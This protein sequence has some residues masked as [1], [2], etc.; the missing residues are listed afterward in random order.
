LPGLSPAG[1]RTEDVSRSFQLKFTGL[2]EGEECV[3][4]SLLAQSFVYDDMNVLIGRVKQSP[5]SY[6]VA[7]DRGRIVAGLGILKMGQW[8]GGRSVPAAGIFLVGVAPEVRGRGAATFLL[9][10]TLKE[11]AA[12]GFPISVLFPSTLPL[13]QRSGYDRAGVRITYEYP[14]SEIPPVATGI[15][16]AA[17]DEANPAEFAPLYQQMAKAATGCLDRAPFTW[18]RAIDPDR[19]K[20]FRYF[21]MENNQRA[22]YVAFGQEQDGTFEIFDYCANSR[23]AAQ[24]ILTF[25]ARQRQLVRS[26]TWHGG[27][28]D[29]LLHVLPEQKA[30]VKRSFEWLVRVVD[31]K[32]ALEYRGWPG[33]VQGEI[34]FSVQDDVM[35]ANND[36]FVLSVREGRGEVKRGGRGSVSIDVRGLASLYTGH[37][38][39]CQLQLLGLLEGPPDELELCSLLFSGPR[40]WM[41]DIF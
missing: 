20:A 39:P 35:P 3:L 14:L 40:P 2:D 4:A 5:G 16:M 13:Y 41:G 32:G 1:E 10:E 30:G 31:V 19:Q 28:G 24:A 15:E 34:H 6:R 33:Q 8:I 37:L 29:L 11:L 9:Q 36:K 18:K 21:V 38:A 26:I 7:R 12:D 23:R 25:F 27:P 17:T 22:G